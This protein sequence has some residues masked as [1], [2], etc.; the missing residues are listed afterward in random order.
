MTERRVVA[1]VDGDLVDEVSGEIIETIATNA[2]GFVDVS[3]VVDTPSTSQTAIDTEAPT[4][5]VPAVSEPAA[6]SP[7][8]AGSL[9]QAQDALLEIPAFLRRYDEKHPAPDSVTV[10]PP[11]R[12]EPQMVNAREGQG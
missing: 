12:S 8:A 6:I 4:P 9:L 1:F 10:V 2:V 11:V 3:N 7:D 5:N